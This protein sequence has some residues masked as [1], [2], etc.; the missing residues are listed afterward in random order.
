MQSQVT[1]VKI[2]VPSMELSIYVTEEFIGSKPLE[3]RFR[4][5]VFDCERIIARIFHLIS[6]LMKYWFFT[7]TKNPIVSCMGLVIC[8]IL[9]TYF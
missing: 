2:L 1:L 5:S 3:A 7:V 6:N 9:P 4:L 8:V